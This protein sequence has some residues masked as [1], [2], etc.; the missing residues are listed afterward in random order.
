MKVSQNQTIAVW[1]TFGEGIN[2][3]ENLD[4][5]QEDKRKG[6][7]G[8]EVKF[9]KILEKPDLLEQEHRTSYDSQRHSADTQKESRFI[10][11]S[12]LPLEKISPPIVK[13]PALLIQSH[14]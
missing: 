10:P 2:D 7:G 13:F 6:S 5:P 11:N 14:W 9:H 8:A 12:D 4:L 1:P 3:R